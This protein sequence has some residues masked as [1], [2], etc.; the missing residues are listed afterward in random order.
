MIYAIITII[1][2][3]IIIFYWLILPLFK[4]L[5]SASLNTRENV[6]PGLLELDKTI[7]TICSA[8][9][10]LTMNLIDKSV[11]GKNYLITSW[12][13]LITCIGIGILILLISYVER[14]TGRVA[15]S[16]I[17]VFRKELKNMNENKKKLEGE[18]SIK[19]LNYHTLLNRT[20]VI[21]IYLLVSS[22]FISFLF[23]IMFGLKNL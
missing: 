21:L 1:I 6:L 5:S 20:L 7:I 4:Y 16:Q 17:A 15:K 22:L 8:A 12:F 13:A 3:L 14:V 19:T 11:I 23:M 2:V 9:I 18:E 10:I